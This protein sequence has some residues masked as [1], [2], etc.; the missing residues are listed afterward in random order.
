MRPGMDRWFALHEVEGASEEILPPHDTGASGGPA[1]L[2]HYESW[3]GDEFVR[4]WSNI[5]TS[6]AMPALRGRRQPTAVAVRALLARDLPA[7]TLR[8]LLLR[9]FQRTTE[10][11]FETLRDLGVLVELHPEA[12][13]HVPAALSESSRERLTTLLAAVAPL[14]KRVFRSGTTADEASRTLGAVVDQLGQAGYDRDEIARCREVWTSG[15][16]AS[17]VTRWARRRGQPSP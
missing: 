9:I 16:D 6:G 7:D 10:D 12:G 1:Q 14:D 8:S 13:G 17:T 3:S 11:D 2:L 4:K 5:V 15:R